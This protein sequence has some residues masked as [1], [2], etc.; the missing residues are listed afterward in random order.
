VFFALLARMKSAT[1]VILTSSPMI[2]R[3]EYAR[4]LRRFILHVYCVYAVDV[5]T[6]D[7]EQRG[8]AP[9]TEGQIR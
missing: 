8:S 6:T 2:I 3:P 1:P 9:P 7:I 4:K 5:Y